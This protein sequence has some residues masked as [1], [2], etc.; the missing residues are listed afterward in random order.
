MLSTGPNRSASTIRANGGDPRDLKRS[1]ILSC[2]N[3]RLTGVI[4][5]HEIEPV[6]PPQDSQHLVEAAAAAD[7]SQQ[8]LVPVKL[9]DQP[10]FPLLRLI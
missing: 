6:I 3:D 1:K 10:A 2:A 4:D 8:H 9:T 5:Q 7:A